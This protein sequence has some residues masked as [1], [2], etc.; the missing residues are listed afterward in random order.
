MATIDIKESLLAH[1]RGMKDQHLLAEI[2]E[3]LK[4]AEAQNVNGIYQLSESQERLLEESRQ[5]IRSGQFLT[6]EEA[7]QEIDEWLGK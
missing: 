2:Y 6:E 4:L 1:I 5:S 7:N 3:W